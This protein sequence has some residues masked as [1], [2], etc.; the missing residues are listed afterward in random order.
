[1]AFSR[2][3]FWRGAIA[4]WVTFNA[5]FLMVTTVVLTIMSRSL[6]TLF[7]ILIMVAWFQLLFVVAASALATIIGSGAAFGLGRLL[8]TTTG[9]RRHLMAFAG[10]GLVVGG[11]VIAVVGVVPAN[12]TGEFG[13][14]LTD[15]SEPYIAL[16]LLGMSAVS[17]AYGWYWSASRALCADPARQSP[18]AEAQPAG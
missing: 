11:V 9:T 10:L 14:V 15:I 7:S 1:M 16:P 3:E 6:Q 13:F 18:V 8:R 17:V 12:L 5:L 2:R 4:A